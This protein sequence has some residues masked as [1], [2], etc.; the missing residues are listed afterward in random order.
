MKVTIING[1]P[2]VGKTTLLHNIL[3]QLPPD[4]AILDGDDVA[5]LHPFD[6]S[7]G[8]VN[9]VHA[10][11][12]ACAV[13]MRQAGV[14]HL[15]IGFVFPGEWAY[16]HLNALFGVADFTP[17]WINLVVDNNCLLSRLQAQGVTR[18]DIFDT[19]IGFNASIRSLAQA[20]DLV[21]ID[22][23]ELNVESICMKV[24]DVMRS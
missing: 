17:A 6:G 23:S 5:R 19:S 15:L 14:K 12:L 8:W 7:L 20:H 3:Q 9:L 10:N 21:C 1:P 18:Q 13:N 2:G 16:Q 4:S 24:L 22:T 11:V